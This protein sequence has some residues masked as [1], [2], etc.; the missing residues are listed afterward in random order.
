[1]KQR[2]ILI[3]CL[4]ILALM[5]TTVALGSCELISGITGSGSGN[6]NEGGNGN[7]NDTPNDNPGENPEDKPEDKPDDSDPTDVPTLSELHGNI[8]AYRR[9]SISSGDRLEASVKEHRDILNA[10]LSGD[11]ELADKLTSRHI[12]AAIENLL[13]V[14]RGK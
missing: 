4:L 7:V 13:K 1:M 6:T 5:L 14:I 8:T 2:R 9:M 12:E 10:I 11:A 3:S